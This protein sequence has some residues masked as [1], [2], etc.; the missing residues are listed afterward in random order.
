MSPVEQAIV[1]CLMRQQIQGRVT[2]ALSGG[3]DS[4]VLL[5]AMHRIQQGVSGKNAPNS[6]PR[7]AFDA[8]HVH[9]GLSPNADA[10]AAFCQQECDRRGIVLNVARVNVNP[11]NTDGQGIEGAAR[12]ARY[13]AFQNEG[14]ATILAAQHADDQA[15]TVLHQLLRGT[16]L[17]GLAAMG[18]VRNLPSGQR[19][20]RP[21]LKL[22]R[23]DI[24]AYAETHQVKFIT[25][26]SN[27]DTTYTRNFIRHELMPLII[28]RF[29]HANGA[30]GR[31]ARHAAESAEM[32]EALATLDLQWDGSLAKAD[33]LDDLP[34]ARQTNA[35]YYWLKWQGV[36][37]PSQSQLEAWAQ[38]LFR[39][40]PTDKPHQ[41]GGHDFIIRRQRDALT[42]LPKPR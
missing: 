19:L 6:P 34:L 17:A 35:L 20:I 21:L 22:A 24:E 9:H 30:L 1:D 27:D 33:G 39:D 7:L 15:E 2:I 25:D 36:A 8:L 10:W 40:S 37:M 3:V 29:P 12:A 4:M 26:E 41:A 11:D 5:D 23:R 32:L 31:T 42:L 38:Q 14:A 13:G 28:E 18:E 16:G